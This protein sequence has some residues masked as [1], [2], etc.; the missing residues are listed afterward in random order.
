[1]ATA[2]PIASQ[3]SSD[4][5]TMEAY[6][7]PRG[8]RPHDVAPAPDGTVWYTAQRLGEL[9][10][11]DPE[12]G[13]TRHIPLGEGSAPHGV[14]VG[15]DDAAWITDG[16]LNAIVRVD[17]ETE[18]VTVYPLPDD[19]PSVNLNT[20]VFDDDG[21]L[22]FTGQNGIYGRL[23]PETGDMEVFDAPRGRGPYGIT[24]TPDGEVYYASL[25]GSFVGHVDT[26]TGE[27]TVLEP[28]TPNQGARRV[29]SDSIGRIWVSE[30][31]GGNV[32]VY[33]P[34][35]DEWQTWRLPGGNPQ[36]Y[37]VYVDEN[38]IV[39]LSDFG[40]NAIVS[41]DPET[42]EFTEFLLP[43]PSGNVRQILGRSGEIWGAE[44]GAD[45]LVVIRLPQEDE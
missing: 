4:E 6:P 33:D 8:S 32:S 20:A 30:W 38:D 1:M 17:A 16:G 34:A 37:A 41:F 28:P 13:E 2:A 24:S 35:N 39:W 43:S 18:E 23:D 45:Q 40:A 19:A 5:P 3:E 27:T 26:E 31:N 25:A 21:M 12:T 11:L 10:I 22:W 44:S 36:T 15:P 42:E 7:V 9:G 29:W 14:I